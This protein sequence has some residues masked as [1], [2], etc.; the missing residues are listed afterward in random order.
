MSVI[1][2]RRGR[3]SS[4]TDYFAG[5]SSSRRPGRP[6]RRPRHGS[7]DGQQLGKHRR[8]AAEQRRGGFEA[9]QSYTAG[10]VPYS[11]N[12]GDFNDDNISDLV[13]ANING[14]DVSVLIGKGDGTFNVART[15]PPELRRFPWPPATST[16]MACPMWPPPMRSLRGPSRC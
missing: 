7:G 1:G 6:R 5:F 11:V 12:L 9:A 3:F 14:G 4:V 16:A 2:G 13:T 10:T 15:P 8:R